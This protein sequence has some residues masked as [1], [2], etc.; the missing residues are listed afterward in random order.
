MDSPFS[1]FVFPAPD[2]VWRPAIEEGAAVYLLGV[3][4]HFVT[5]GSPLEGEMTAAGGVRVGTLRF[6]ADPTE[7]W[8]PRRSV[9]SVAPEEAVRGLRSAPGRN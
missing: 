2:I 1:K 6:D 9:R 8:H 3:A 7:R 5:P 4:L